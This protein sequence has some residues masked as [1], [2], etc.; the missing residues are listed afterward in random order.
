M[1]QPI[2]QQHI[3]INLL[4]NHHF[5]TPLTEEI[6]EKYFVKPVRLELQTIYAFKIITKIQNETNTVYQYGIILLN[7]DLF[8]LY[9]LDINEYIKYKNTNKLFQIF[10]NVNNKI[11]KRYVIL[12]N[13]F[14]SR[15]IDNYN[16]VDGVEYT[17]YQRSVDAGVKEFF[18]KESNVY[19]SSSSSNRLFS[20][21]SKK[22]LKH[23]PRTRNSN[24]SSVLKD[25]YL[26]S[27]LNT[28]T[29]K[30]GGKYKKTKTK[31]K[32]RYY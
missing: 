2:Q 18:G 10:Q 14:V 12:N 32:K 19:N 26:S 28:Y 9:T 25:P 1:E 21:K 30:K 29:M 20:K 22:L 11:F 4:D 27:F 3:D 23:T 7:N 17:A 5:Y 15:P 24:V 8:K 16:N 31:T 13:G 6:I